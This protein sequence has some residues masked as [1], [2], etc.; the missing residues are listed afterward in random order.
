MSNAPLPR[1]IRIFSYSQPQPPHP[2]D[3]K[4]VEFSRENRL[5]VSHTGDKP[6]SAL[7][8]QKT[9]F[10]GSYGPGTT[11]PF[12][13]INSPGCY[14][15]NWSGHLIRVPQDGVAAGRPAGFNIVGT[16][17][18]YVTMISENPFL[19]ATKARLLASNY[20]VAVNF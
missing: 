16:D 13:A 5:R 4:A 9:P 14:I 11:L 8:T 2:T 3:D 12:E 6:M 10:T 19:P 1:R 17:P 7:S 15:C 18:L 20:D